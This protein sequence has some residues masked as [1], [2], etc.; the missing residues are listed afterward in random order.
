MRPTEYL[1]G[2]QCARFALFRRTHS[3][4]VEASQV[5]RPCTVSS[6]SRVLTL[7]NFEDSPIS[8]ST[9][10][11]V[12]SVVAP[13]FISNPTL[14]RFIGYSI[15]RVDQATLIAYVPLSGTNIQ[16]YLGLSGSVVS[17]PIRRLDHVRPEIGTQS[18][19]I[20][21]WAQCPAWSVAQLVFASIHRFRC[22]ATCE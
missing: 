21:A 13:S 8:D 19:M 12:A 16:L 10:S 15:V 2:T 7:S 3:S 6:H 20:P 17:T 1:T 14:E 22:V 4:P 5:S 18:T 11:A 9:Y